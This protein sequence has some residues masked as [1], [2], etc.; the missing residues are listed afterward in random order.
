MGGFA[1]CGGRESINYA[2]DGGQTSAIAH[3]A[4]RHDDV[5]SPVARDDLF[6]VDRSMKPKSW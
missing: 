2:I 5:I 3:R 6:P 1:I 4:E